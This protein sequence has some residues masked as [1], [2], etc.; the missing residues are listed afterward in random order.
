MRG[1]EHKV[2]DVITLDP[3]KAG[4]EN[5][6]AQLL[7]Q[8]V[9]F[10]LPMIIISM[11]STMFSKDIAYIIIMAIGLVF[12]ATHRLWMRNIYRRLMKRRYVNLAAF[13]AS[14]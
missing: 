11:M 10:G 2:V 6:Y 1:Y 14:R 7:A 5:S 9:S 3:S 13:R 12:I 8:A 4:M